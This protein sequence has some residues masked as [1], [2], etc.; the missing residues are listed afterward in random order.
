MPVI[1]GIVA[2]GLAAVGAATSIYGAIAGNSAQS[3]AIA[4]QQHAEQIRQQAA[5]ADAE[6]RRRQAIR[7]GIIAR[8]QALTKETAQGAN[9]SSAV[10][11][12][13]G[14][15]NQ[16]TGWRVAG[17]NQA[18]HFGT[19]LYGANQELLAARQ[20][21]ANASSISDIGKGISSLGNA[22]IVQQGPINNL[23]G[24]D[25]FNIVSGVG[26]PSANA[27]T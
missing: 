15:I 16:E 21:Q 18:Q 2:A 23:A 9:E 11:G 22:L 19:E 8:S 17:I 25:P 7:Q 20:D 13:G 24:P 6:R 4:A 27:Y 10:G 5:A 12:A 3:E 26:K 1:T 14:Q